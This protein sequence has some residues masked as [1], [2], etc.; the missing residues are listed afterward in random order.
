LFVRPLVVVIMSMW[1]LLLV[2]QETE[3]MMLMITM[4]TMRTMIKV[5]IKGCGFYCCCLVAEISG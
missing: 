3:L 2:M 5:E 1:V 4:T